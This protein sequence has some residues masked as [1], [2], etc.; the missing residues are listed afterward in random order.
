MPYEILSLFIKPFVIVTEYTL[1]TFPSFSV[2]LGKNLIL[3]LKNITKVF[4]DKKV[5]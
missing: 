2:I 1:F 4:Y 5:I 3:I